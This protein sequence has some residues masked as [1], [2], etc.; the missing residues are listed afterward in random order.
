MKNTDKTVSFGIPPGSSGFSEAVLQ[1]MAI[2]RAGRGVDYQPR[3]RHLDA[4]GWA[5]YTNRLFLENSP[6]LLQHAHNPVD[7]FPWCNDAFDRA[8]ELNRPVLLSVGYSTCHWC[9]VMEEESFEDEEIATFINQNYV[10]VKVDREERPDIDAVYMSAVQALTGRGGWP[11]TMLLTPDRKPFYGGTYFPAR[12]GDRGVPTGFFSLLKRLKTAYDT[13]GE[14]VAAAGSRFAA[15]VQQ[16]LTPRKGRGVPD[17]SI[18]QQAADEYKARFD[19]IEGGVGGAPKFPSSLPIRFLLRHG[20]HTGDDQSV[21]M[22]RLTLRKMADGG[23]YDHVG[24]GFHRYSTD[25][26]WRVPHFEKMLY[27]NALLAA[28]YIEG[29]Q[30][31]G[32]VVFRHTAEEILNYVTGEMTSPDGGFFS[33]TDADSLTPNGLREEGYFFTW[34]QEELSSVLE[35]DVN[36]FVRKYYNINQNPDFEERY[37]LH[38]TKNLAAIG[39]TL[40]MSREVAAKT[41]ETARKK[42]Y[43]ARSKR[44]A[45]LLDNKILTAWNALMISAFAQA[46]QI[47]GSGEYIER[48]E[49][50]ARFVSTNLYRNGRLYRSFHG[51][52]ARHKAYLDDYA[53]LISGLID[54]FEATGKPDYLLQALRFER[55]LETLF[56][57]QENGG[58]FLTG[59]DTEALIAREKPGYDG[60]LPSGNSVAIL[61]LLRLAAFTADDQYR[62]RAEKVLICFAENL[63]KAPSAFGDMLMAL[64][65]YYH[66]PQEIVITAPSE[67]APSVE[68]FLAALRSRYLPN[69]VLA[70]RYEDRGAD[71]ASGTISL[72]KG[73]KSIN[74]RVTAYVCE[75]GACSLPVQTPEELIHKIELAG[76]VAVRPR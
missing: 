48:A 25:D 74:N 62:R 36:E 33:A 28:A 55:E 22:A 39:D 54:L 9:H 60:A 53:F 63:N 67:K 52:Q 7:W 72:L 41:L 34:T 47:L 50:A 49:K 32:E 26:R 11:L 15:A 35:K 29:Y 30:A 73:K 51:G 23:M 43:Q 21:E 19:K 71:F 27:D 1:Q 37:V 61:N 46:G 20:H 57:D 31:T 68:Q 59:N 17:R 66:K 65:L 64:D 70:V 12:D 45:P 76:G 13:Q 69:R 24:G 10:P 2:V 5:Q 4:D 38:K 75:E 14:Q 6:Y 16:M 3:T 40:G 8:I 18:L 42:L 44:P 56:E 58:F